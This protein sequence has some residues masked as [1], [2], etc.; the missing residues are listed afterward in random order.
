LAN[1]KRVTNGDRL[2]YT[3]EPG[4]VKI[5]PYVRGVRRTNFDLHFYPYCYINTQS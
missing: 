4:P 3:T 5:T 1:Q 2:A